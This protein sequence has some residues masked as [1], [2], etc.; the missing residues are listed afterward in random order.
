MAKSDLRL[1]LLRWI[2]KANR[3]QWRTGPGGKE[4]WGF[5]MSKICFCMKQCPLISWTEWMKRYCWFRLAQ[6]WSQNLPI[7]VMQIK[8]SLIWGSKQILLRVASNPNHKNKRS[9]F[10]WS[11]QP[12]IA[13]SSHEN[14]NCHIA[15]IT[16]CS[17]FMQPYS[18]RKEEGCRIILAA[19]FTQLSTWL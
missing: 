19:R 17:K 13:Y 6:W 15:D 8:E 5:E 16:G 10:H 1:L 18:Q 9:S 11:N 2:R 4:R 3:E 12:I 7:R 14:K